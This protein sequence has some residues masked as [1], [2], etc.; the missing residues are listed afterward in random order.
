MTTVSCSVQTFR[1]MLNVSSK[2]K[3]KNNII[4]RRK[5][6]EQKNDNQLKK[7]GK[8]I[9]NKKQKQTTKNNSSEKWNIISDAIIS[10]KITE[11]TTS[12]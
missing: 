11:K 7:I 5:S 2:G 9:H 8:Q 10:K 4:K 3:M 12:I 1:W 6:F